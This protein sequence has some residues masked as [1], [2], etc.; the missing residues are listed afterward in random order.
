MT[1]PSARV[2]NSAINLL[3]RWISVLLSLVKFNAPLVRY[4]ELQGTARLL[5]KRE[6]K[7][8]R[9]QTSR[10]RWTKIQERVFLPVEKTYSG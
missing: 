7:L 5:K 2:P 1:G 9:L 4:S 3:T 8:G 10:T 6:K